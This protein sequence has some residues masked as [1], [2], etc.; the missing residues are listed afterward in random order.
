VYDPGHD[1]LIWVLLYVNVDNAGNYRPNTVRLAVANGEAGIANTDFHFTS[2]IPSDVGLGMDWFD[3]PHIEL[4]GNY[5]FLSVNLFT[6]NVPLDQTQFD[7][8]VV[9]RLPLD[10]L[11]AHTAPALSAWLAPH[12]YFNATLTQGAT[13]A[14]YW[15]THLDTSTLVVYRWSESSSAPDAFGLVPHSMYPWEIYTCPGPGGADWCGRLDDRVLT[16]WVSNG[17]IG[18]MWNAPGGASGYGFKPHPYIQTVLVNASTMDLRGE[19]IM[20]GNERTYAYPGA[21]LNA[22]GHVAG[23]LFYGSPTE[24][25]TL[26][27]FIWD[28][29]T[30]ANPYPSIPYSWELYKIAESTQG[31]DEN[32]WG[33]FL[34]ARSNYD[35]ACSKC[36]YTWIATGYV[37]VGGGSNDHVRPR[38]L[39]FGRGRDNPYPTIYQFL[40]FIIK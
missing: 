7:R 15:A 14:M 9:M 10:A 22:R 23:T 5:L 2:L 38:Y 17:I 21:G 31:P 3:Y 12:S 39:A 8:T 35:P 27:A 32:K 24:P 4:S 34:T 11:A 26:A 18:F 36:Q 28:D 33:D 13:T 25:P 1:I 29:L 16:G 40:P 37:L 6:G 30:P 20:W 19:S